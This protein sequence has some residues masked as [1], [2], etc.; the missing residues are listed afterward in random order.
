MTC[1]CCGCISASP[2]PPFMIA[3]STSFRPPATASERGVVKSIGSANG[4]C[5]AHARATQQQRRNV[6]VCVA[7]TGDRVAF[8]GIKSAFGDGVWGCCASRALHSCKRASALAC[9]VEADECTPPMASD[10]PATCGCISVAAARIC[11][12]GIAQLCTNQRSAN[13]C[14]AA[15]AAA[16]ECGLCPTTR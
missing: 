10:N 4:R 15:R 16:R 11:S 6:G 3:S 12:G 7:R 9:R 14:T 1:T 2:M 5:T 13:A 8:K